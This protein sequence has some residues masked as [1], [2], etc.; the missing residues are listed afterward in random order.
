MAHVTPG[1]LL[2]AAAQRRSYLVAKSTL[3]LGS[4]FSVSFYIKDRMYTFAGCV[5]PTAE[6]YE[7]RSL[8][9]VLCYGCGILYDI[10][11]RKKIDGGNMNMA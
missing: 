7:S 10:C 4:D 3:G 8:Q 1:Y 9:V 6:L 11:S 5:L 2:L